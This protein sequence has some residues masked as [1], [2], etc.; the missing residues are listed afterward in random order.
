MVDA[1]ANDPMTSGANEAA[2]GGVATV[3][4]TPEGSG[5]SGVGPRGSPMGATRAAAP[6]EPPWRGVFASDCTNEVADTVAGGSDKRD[7]KRAFAA[8]VGGTWPDG[9]LAG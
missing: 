2:T 7:C 3:V 6:A 4:V 5:G 1:P 9:G 8:G